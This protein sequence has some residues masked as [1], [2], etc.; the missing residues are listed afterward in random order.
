MVV[1]QVICSQMD[2]YTR[3][4]SHFSKLSA[5]KEPISNPCFVTA[6]VMNVPA[7]GSVH[8]HHPFAGCSSLHS[9]LRQWSRGDQT[10]GGLGG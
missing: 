10:M 2:F 3:L 1:S 4:Q 7:D 5:C 8:Q 9:Q 6:S